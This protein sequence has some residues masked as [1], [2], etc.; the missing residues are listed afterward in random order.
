LLKDKPPAEKWAAGLKQQVLALAR[1]T[2]VDV[3]ERLAEEETVASSKKVA[4]AAKGPSADDV[5]RA[6]A[7]APDERQAMIRGMVD[8]LAARLKDSPRDPEGWI[9]LIRSRSVMKEPEKA[10]DALKRAK[11]VF[12]DDAQLRQRIVAAAQAIG[13]TAD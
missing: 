9:R 1:K 7:M 10:R 4:A 3:S 8:G 12:A 11:E 13:V 6:Q 2:G 5:R